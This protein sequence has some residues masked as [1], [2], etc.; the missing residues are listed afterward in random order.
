MIDLDKLTI[1][2]WA[3]KDNDIEINFYEDGIVDLLL[4]RDDW[5][6]G[7]PIGEEDYIRRLSAIMNHEFMHWIIYEMVGI[8]EEY[9]EFLKAISIYSID[10]FLKNW[11]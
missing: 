6:K 11:L 10:G 1:V 8:Q 5:L 2:P 3:D 4:K 9:D 7:T